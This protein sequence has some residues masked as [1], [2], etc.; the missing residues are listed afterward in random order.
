V[1]AVKQFFW[2][3]T[4]IC[5]P[6]VDS[7]L[8]AVVEI[9]PLLIADDGP[10]PCRERAGEQGAK[11]WRLQAQTG[12]FKLPNRCYYRLRKCSA[13]RFG[14]RSVFVRHGLCFVR[15]FFCFG[16]LHGGPRFGSVVGPVVRSVEFVKPL[17]KLLKLREVVACLRQFLRTLQKVARTVVV[18]GVWSTA[19]CDVAVC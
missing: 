6:A 14:R 15:A 3:L 8:N 17:V 11:D 13:G 16:G 12:G 9:N 4:S 7:N 1:A 19:G 2:R 5:Q 10:I 18:A